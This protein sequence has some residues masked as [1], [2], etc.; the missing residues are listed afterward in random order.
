MEIQFLYIN[1][2][3]YEGPAWEAMIQALQEAGKLEEAVIEKIMVKD[4]AQAGKLKFPGS[5]SIRINGRDV[6]PGSGGDAGLSCRLQ[7][8]GVEAIKAVLNEGGAAD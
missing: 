5:P 7:P 1:G 8:P 2:C 3:P 6:A 4:E